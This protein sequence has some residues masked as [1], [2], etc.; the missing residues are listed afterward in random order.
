MIA[1]ANC[2]EWGLQSSRVLCIVSILLLVVT[3]RSQSLPSDIATRSYLV[4]AKSYDEYKQAL[5]LSRSDGS[6]TEE[7]ISISAFVKN[8]LTPEQRVR[9]TAE[10][11]LPGLGTQ[12]PLNAVKA[13]ERWLKEGV[14][15]TSTTRSIVVDSVMAEIRHITVPSAGRR[16]AD[17]SFVMAAENVL[18]A[19]G[20]CNALNLIYCHPARARGFR[21]EETYDENSSA[22]LLCEVAARQSAKPGASKKMLQF[23]SLLCKCSSEGHVITSATLPNIQ[24]LYTHGG[25][26]LP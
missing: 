3:C 23:Y 6:T 4:S 7:R 14:T 12:G 18:L 2:C 17:I 5:I 15:L 8:R 10:V 26:S 22:E 20:D 16:N 1:K 13:I 21:G 11:Y 19:I 25:S 9:I 24:V